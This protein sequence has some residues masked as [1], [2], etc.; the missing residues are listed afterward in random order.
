MGKTMSRL[1]SPIKFL[2]QFVPKILAGTKTA[3]RRLMDVQP[4][5]HG[6]C[7][8]YDGEPFISDDH[9]QEHLQHNV[10]GAHG[11]KWGGVY[12]RGGDLMWVQE[13]WAPNYTGMPGWP[14]H[15]RADLPEDPDA[16]M[17]AN[18]AFGLMTWQ[19]A[20]EMHI[21]NCR[22]W[23]ELVDVEAQRIQAITKKEVIAEGYEGLEDVHAGWHQPFAQSWDSIYPGSWDR[24]DWVWALTFKRVEAPQ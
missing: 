24:N 15:Y 12:E 22:C 21:A 20:G 14:I 3:T 17:T 5:P 19:P 11:T 7:W 18:H 16:A 4:E 1:R 6:D 8:I 2:P 23:L 10:Y 9:M 13:P